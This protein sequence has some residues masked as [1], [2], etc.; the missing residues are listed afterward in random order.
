MARAGEDWRAFPASC[1]F[2]GQNKVAWRVTVSRPAWAFPKCRAE[3]IEKKP[4]GWFTGHKSCPIVLVAWEPCGIG[5]LLGVATEN[6]GPD[7]VT[8]INDRGQAGGE[9]PAV[10]RG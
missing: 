7:L 6:T 10:G 4:V 3:A 9:D 2:G 8:G 1:W 5:E